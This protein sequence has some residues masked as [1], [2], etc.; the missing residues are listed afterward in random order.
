MKVDFSIAGS[1]DK[2]Y[3]PL[4]FRAFHNNQGYCYMRVQNY[5]GL[6]IFTCAQLLNYYSTS[7]TNAVEAVRQ[8]IVNTLIN[9]GVISFKKQKGFLDI[10]KSEQRISAEF[11][12]QFWE[13]INKNSIWIEYYDKEES[14]YFDTHY[15]LVTFQE[16]TSPSWRRTSLED[17]QK[18]Y[19]GYDF[20][21]PQ[22]HLKHWGKAR[23]TLEEIKDVLKE[24]GWSNKALAARWGYSEVWVSKIINNRD[25]D[26]QWEDAF[27]GLPPY[28]KNVTDTNYE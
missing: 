11:I 14:I 4:Q 27:R 5:N 3:L 9:E 7:V 17:L 13:F 24:K 15:D 20:I 22:D 1:Y 18:R 21:V 10:L 25:R 23:M 28:E 6:M 2:V 12:S 16:N 26:I 19:P 8:S